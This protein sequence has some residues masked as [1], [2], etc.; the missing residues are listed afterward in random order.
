MRVYGYKDNR[1]GI[2]E[3]GNTE[4]A[5]RQFVQGSIGTAGLTGTLKLVYNKD[6]SPYAGDSKLTA[7]WYDQ[8]ELV[9]IICGSCF[10]CRQSEDGLC[11][12]RDSDIPAI[13]KILKS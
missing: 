3:I 4:K 8:D 11:S 12:V 9:D 6:S 1:E 10:V 2:M 5:F 13:K 7:A